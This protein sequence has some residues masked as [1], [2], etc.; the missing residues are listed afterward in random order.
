M[1]TQSYNHYFA[2]Y[3]QHQCKSTY[4][5][6][7]FVKEKI[8]TCKNSMLL[9]MKLLLDKFAKTYNHQLWME[10]RCKTI[11]TA[12]VTT[13]LSV[14]T[15]CLCKTK[16]ITCYLCKIKVITCCQCKTNNIKYQTTTWTKYLVI[17]KYQCKIN[18]IK[19]QITT[20]TKCLTTIISKTKENKIK[21]LMI[22]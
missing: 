18:N 13:C 9:V 17:T 16:V 5:L 10:I 8:S 7:T 11:I 21:I 4:T 20:W 6:E 15:C 2:I 14:I 12:K 1:L 19:Y 3:W 22:Y